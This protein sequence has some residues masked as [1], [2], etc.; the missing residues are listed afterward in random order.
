MGRRLVAPRVSSLRRMRSRSWQSRSSPVTTGR[1][2]RVAPRCRAVM[3]RA[4][5]SISSIAAAAGT[6][7]PN[8]AATTTTGI[9]HPS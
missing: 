3:L 7:A 1:G 2:L 8:S 5:R 9:R 4:R 6:A